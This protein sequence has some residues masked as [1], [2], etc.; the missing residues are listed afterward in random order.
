MIQWYEVKA[1]PRTEKSL[2]SGSDG[3]SWRVLVVDGL[4][5]ACSGHPHCPVAVGEEWGP[6]MAHWKGWPDWTVTAL[7]PENT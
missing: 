5:A 1:P 6:R 2:G 7:D 3:M 4:V